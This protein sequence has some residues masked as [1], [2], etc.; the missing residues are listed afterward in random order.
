M[1][2]IEY[3]Q[4]EFRFKKEADKEFIFDEVRKQ[5][6]RLTPEEW[7]R[8]N[9]LQYLMQ[10]KKYPATLIAVEKEIKLG[11]LK[12]RCD[13]IVY[14]NQLPWMIVECKEMNVTLSQSTIE[15][16]LRYNMVMKVDYLVIT[17]GN[18]IYA[19]RITD[20]TVNEINAI[21]EFI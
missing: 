14:K 11:E 20:G 9:F 10:S 8:Q 15:Q 17:N 6:L 18:S 2:Q 16:I 5:W 21:P 1:I 3:P 4:Y 13:I 12:K 19:W 7:V